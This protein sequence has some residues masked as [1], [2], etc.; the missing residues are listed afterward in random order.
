MLI[1]NKMKKYTIIIS[2]VLL[3]IFF[4]TPASAQENRKTYVYP[5]SLEFNHA[6]SLW[7]NSNNAAGLT[8]T[9]LDNYNEV[10]ATCKF[11]DGDYK[12]QQSGDRIT[13]TAFNTNGALR[14]GKVVL[15]GDFN[16]ANRFDRAS[17]YNTMLYQV[18]DDMPYYVAD[19]QVSNWKR[20]LYDMSLKAATP[21]L[22][23]RL[24]IG[25]TANYTTR[26]GAKQKDP[27]STTYYYHVNVQPALILRLGQHYV[28]LNGL[29]ENMFERTVPT[30]SD[31]QND[32]PV[33]LMR[34]LGN[35]AV[36]TV[37]GLGGVGT[38]YYKGN[39]VGGGLEY[40]KTGKFSFLLD[41]NYRLRVID[42]FQSPTKPQRMGSTKNQTYR[43][44]LQLMLDGALTNKLAI[45]YYRRSTDG[46]EYIQELDKTYEVQQWI[47]IAKFIR[48]NYAFKALSLNYDLFMGREKGYGWR[49][50]A[51]AVYSDR[52]DEYYLPDSHL[53]TENFYG[54]IFVKKN[55]DLGKYSALLAGLNGGY[56]KNL[57]GEYVY[58]GSYAESAVVT[59]FYAADFAFLTADYWQIGGNINFSFP[60]GL[61]DTALYLDARADWLLP[62]NYDAAA[63]SSNPSRIFAQ[64]SV[65]FT[66]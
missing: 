57:S 17:L 64:F 18:A 10:S 45:D 21:L 37:G 56:N 25:I 15:W 8:V 7:F 50:G 35:Y 39:K 19:P 66:F 5:A 32:Q 54:E 24:G 20:Q 29:Y 52:R 9:P 30:N 34:G 49:A 44:N 16:F 28:G 41:L 47:T 58:N 1:F 43:G 46:V 22:W 62:K 11:E 38:F 48:S 42:V 63:G 51:K 12:R 33:F 13:G 27:R 53:S 36:G 65:G 23:D 14:L 26:T 4:G 61:G 31:N 2:A 59:D 55:F 40:G 60:L 6:R 3:G